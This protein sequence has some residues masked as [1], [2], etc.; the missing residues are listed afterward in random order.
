MAQYVNTNMRI[1]VDSFELAGFARSLTVDAKLTPE[2]F[3]NLACGGNKIW[4][5]GLAEHSVVAQGFQGFDT[6]DP[7]VILPAQTLGGQAAITVVPVN[8][9]TVGDAAFMST[10][11]RGKTSPLAGAVGKPAMFDMGWLGDAR[12]VR[13]SVLHPLAARTATG[14]GTIVAFTPPTATQTLWASFHVTSVTG[15]GT[16]TFTVRTDD[17]VGFSSPTT[18]ITSNAFAAIGGQVASAAGALTGETHIR[19]TYT[20]SGFTSV[21]F[22]CAYGVANT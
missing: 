19:L 5:A 21:T 20:I 3:T 13:S 12:L 22:L 4:K 8:T 10:A 11:I 7:D 17:A 6:M 2:D 15:S 9:E 18:R 1:L 16:I 14:N